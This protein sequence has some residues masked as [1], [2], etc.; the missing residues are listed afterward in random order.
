MSI[1]AVLFL[2]CS[3]LLAP[4]AQEGVLPEATVAVQ[5]PF[6]RSERSNA[7]AASLIVV[8]QKRVD[9]HW[10]TYRIRDLF[11]DTEINTLFSPNGTLVGREGE[12]MRTVELSRPSVGEW[13]IVSWRRLKPGGVDGELKAVGSFVTPVY[14]S[15][16]PDSVLVEL[17][18]K[19]RVS[20]QLLDGDGEPCVRVNL[21]VVAVELDGLREPDY[22]ERLRL[23]SL[24]EGLVHTVVTTDSEGRFQAD[25]L[26]PGDFALGIVEEPLDDEIDSLWSTMGNPTYLARP[27]PNVV[28]ADGIFRTFEAELGSLTVTIHN[29][30]GAIV[31]MVTHPY[32]GER[33]EWA[34]K[35]TIELHRFIEGQLDVRPV[36][37][38]VH[39]AV[40]DQLRYSGLIPGTYRFYLKTPRHGLIERTVEVAAGHAQI[41]FE[42]L[43]EVPLGTVRLSA[44]PELAQAAGPKFSAEV[45]LFLRVFDSSGAVELF[46]PFVVLGVK[47]A[48]E[49]ALPAGTYRAE[50]H[51]PKY[52]GSAGFPRTP[53][54]AAPLLT[55]E[56]RGNEHSELEVPLQRGGRLEIEFIAPP[57]ASELDR[58]GRTEFP[59]NDEIALNRLV[60]MLERS[61][62]L[63][64]RDASGAARCWLGFEASVGLLALPHDFESDGQ[65]LRKSTGGSNLLFP[66]AYSLELRLPGGRLVTR[67]V[68]IESGKTTKVLIELH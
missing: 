29:A 47:E 43:E 51:D 10:A 35:P 31:P 20:G 62:R 13:R 66:G 64:L 22:E 17:V 50:L 45:G 34:S 61:R 24:G 41:D 68:E 33:E 49:I 46:N 48:A 44:W 7:Y 55:F 8:V 42:L 30:A 63:T 56:V 19:G 14:G 40:Q 4:R 21:A 23:E 5:A 32:L 11:K 37:P 3:S 67:E 6:L 59:M 65:P 18:G 53:M 57:N 38:R 28:T 16:G 9:D 1:L 60:A 15:D 26:R 54:Y 25:G 52:V 58:S 27:S 36:R 2:A 12:V 39:Q